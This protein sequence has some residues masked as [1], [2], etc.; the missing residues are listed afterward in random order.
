ML[1]K[2]WLSLSPKISLSFAAAVFVSATAAHAALIV[3][4]GNGLVVNDTDLNVAWTQDANLFRT[5]AA[6]DPNLVTSI[7]N[8]T[9]SVV[10]GLGTHIMVAADFNSSAG[11]MNWWGANAWVN[12]LNS[13]S[14]AGETDWRLPII[15]PVNGSTL[16]PTVSFDGST[17]RGFNSAA[18]NGTASELAHLFYHEL[19]NLGQFNTVGA[20][21]SGFGVTNAGP[22]ANLENNGY[23]SGT[24][25]GAEYTEGATFAWIFATANGAQ[26]AGP[27]T[28]QG[29]LFPYFGWA[30][31][32]G[33][34]APVPVPAAV[35]LF[36]SGLI[37]LVGLA[38]RKF[39]A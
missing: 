34:V 16:N 25:A 35:Y 7:I 5:Q 2:L 30:V 32:P 29:S 4:A 22:F 20:T 3:P 10:D 13:I 28:S 26:G 9:P 37:G 11:T 31:S 33:Q 36:G 23:W 12:Y 19:G 27:K 18:V 8:V 38:R 17:D 21:Q 14:Y 15:S 24:E 39:S 6:A 1:H